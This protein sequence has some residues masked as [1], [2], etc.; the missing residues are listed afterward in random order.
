[1][2]SPIIIQTYKNNTH[3]NAEREHIN[4]SKEDLENSKIMVSRAVDVLQSI[5]IKGLSHTMNQFNS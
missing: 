2:P 4:V 3:I 5:L 1:M